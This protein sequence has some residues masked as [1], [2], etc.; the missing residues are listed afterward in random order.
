MARKKQPPVAQF[1]QPNL[2]TIRQSG[3]WQPASQHCARTCLDAP[4]RQMNEALVALVDMQHGTTGLIGNTPRCARPK[5]NSEKGAI[6]R[7]R[8]NGLPELLCVWVVEFEEEHGA[9]GWTG[10]CR[11]APCRHILQEELQVTLRSFAM[12]V[13]ELRHLPRTKAQGSGP[14]KGNVSS[15]AH[16][17]YKRF[18]RVLRAENT[19]AKR[20]RAG[21]RPC[22]KGIRVAILVIPGASHH[23]P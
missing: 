3:I 12:K 18:S 19:S 22:S 9:V 5:E 11:Q 4:S 6:Q 23:L 20:R 2:Q 8:G 1:Q 14:N 7:R 17:R 16:H 10:H 15:C 21:E 13:L